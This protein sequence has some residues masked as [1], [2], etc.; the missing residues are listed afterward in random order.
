MSSPEAILAFWFQGDRH[1]FQERWFQRDD[2]FDD[3]IRAAFAALVPAAREGRLDVWAETPP[4]ALALLLVLD[5]F[6]RNL[7][8]NSAEAFASDAHA[9]AIARRV[10]LERRLD[11]ALTPTERSFLYLPFEHGEA[12]ADQDLSVALFE[13]LRDDPVHRAPGGTI[14]YAWRHRAVI[15]RFG[16]FPHRNAVLGRESTPA[17]LAWLAAGGGF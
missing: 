1:A 5:Q 16:R 14:D 8:R 11:L 9:R 7:H 17:E 12:M 10:V 4:G 3:A 15:Q 2:A 13:G 6:P